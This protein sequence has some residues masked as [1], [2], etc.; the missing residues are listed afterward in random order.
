MI[1]K[2]DSDAIRFL[3]VSFFTGKPMVVLSVHNK[4]SACGFRNWADTGN[5]T[6][7]YRTHATAG[8]ALT[9]SIW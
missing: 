4:F 6:D 8:T 5:N 7:F 3:A 2:E 9:I 1:S